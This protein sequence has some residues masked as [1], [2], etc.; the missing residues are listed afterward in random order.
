[1]FPYYGRLF[2]DHIFAHRQRKSPPTGYDCQLGAACEPIFEPM[3]SCY[4][5]QHRLY[6][7][8]LPHGQGALRPG[9]CC[10]ARSKLFSL[11]GD[12]IPKPKTPRPNVPISTFSGCSAQEIFIPNSLERMP[13]LFCIS[14]GVNPGWRPCAYGCSYHNNIGKTH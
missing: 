8:P 6:F 1:M 9:F 2:V 12:G 14:S 13:I 7:F 5:P 11:R 10:S 4:L 3:V